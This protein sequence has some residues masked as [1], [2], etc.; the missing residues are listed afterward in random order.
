MPAALETIDYEGIVNRDP[1]EIDKLLKACQAATGKGLFF[2]DLRCPA[3]KQV[4]S[5]LPK[6][7]QAMLSYFSQPTET[8]MKDYREG[9]E[10]G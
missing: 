9:V 3:G 2:L 10:R 5:D 8:K 4:L 6:F 1:A 7:G